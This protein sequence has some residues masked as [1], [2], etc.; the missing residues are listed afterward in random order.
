MTPIDTSTHDLIVSMTELTTETRAMV[1]RFDKMEALVENQGD[2]ITK[3]EVWRARL[4]GAVA[5]LTF[6]MPLLV[7]ALQ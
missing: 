6:S 5:V 3:L 4:A 2:R 1:S 7:V